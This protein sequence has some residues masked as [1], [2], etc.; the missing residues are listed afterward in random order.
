MGSYIACHIISRIPRVVCTFLPIPKDLTNPGMLAQKCLSCLSI[1]RLEH[2][3]G[4]R[5]YSVSFIGSDREEKQKPIALRR[6]I[7]D[8][9]WL[10]IR[11]PTIPTVI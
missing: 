1:P 6:W 5:A 7:L 3:L 2:L 11:L 9:H 4:S 8:R 10:I